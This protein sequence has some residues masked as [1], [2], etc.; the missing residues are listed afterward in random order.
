MG[1]VEGSIV[2]R[3]PVSWGRLRAFVVAAVLIAGLVGFGLGRVVSSGTIH[4]AP[5]VFG[6]PTI[7][8][9]QGPGHVPRVWVAR[10]DGTGGGR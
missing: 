6:A 3:T 4:P 1:S 2:T 10:A 8:G 9:H 7:S 5:V